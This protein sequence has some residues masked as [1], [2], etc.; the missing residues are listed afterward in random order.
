M[1]STDAWGFW[2]ITANGLNVIEDSAGRKGREKTE[3]MGNRQA[4]MSYWL[5]APARTQTFVI[6]NAD[7]VAIGDHHQTK[8]FRIDGVCRDAWTNELFCDEGAYIDLAG[9]AS[10]TA[11]GDTEHP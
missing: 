6:T 3:N 2:K 8:S 10:E 4:E 11:E 7:E 9:Y 1:G 5:E